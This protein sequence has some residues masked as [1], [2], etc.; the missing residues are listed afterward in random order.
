MN[1]MHTHENLFSSNKTN[2][3]TEYTFV[4]Y[5]QIPNNLKEGE[6]DII[7]KTEDNKLYY[8]TPEENDI[9]IFS[10]EIEHMAVPTKSVSEERLVYAS[11][12]SF[13]LNKFVEHKKPIR[14]KNYIYSKI[15]N[16]NQDIRI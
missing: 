4:F 8:Y 10:G 9:L 5:I 13:D 2:L 15:F 14:F 7:F 1:W 11:N 3:K 12:L 16:K 6:G